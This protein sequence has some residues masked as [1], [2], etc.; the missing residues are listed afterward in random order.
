M[1]TCLIVPTIRPDSFNRFAQEWGPIADWDTTFVVFDG[2]KVP[3]G[4]DFGTLPDMRVMD[5]VKVR[6]QFG[7]AGAYAFN[8]VNSSCRGA[9]FVR[10]WH[11]G[12]DVMAT[13]DDD[14]YPDRTGT[15]AGLMAQ[16]IK[17]MD[18]TPKWCESIPQ[19]R[20]RGFPYYCD[21]PL[22]TVAAN[23]ALW[24]GVADFDG[25]TQMAFGVRHDF[26]PPRYTRVMPRG[27]FWPFCSM[28]FAIKRPYVPFIFAPPNSAAPDSRFDRMDDIWFG[29]ILEAVL[30]K[31]GKDI[32]CGPPIIRHERASNVLNNM[33]Q[34]A[35]G[36]F[37][38]EQFY[39]VVQ[40]ALDSVDFSGVDPVSSPL[41]A[42]SVMRQLALGFRRA[43][44]S[45]LIKE[46]ARKVW[47]AECS[48]KMTLWCQNFDLKY[49]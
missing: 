16:H 26:E 23:H 32:T 5:R 7:S 39:K 27:Q 43:S 22:D 42:V 14:C 21:T 34:E 13:L 4:L 20:T 29:V 31:L 40:F 8:Q 24:C 18:N 36:V 35:P 19:T 28:N 9:A 47:Y 46:P 1:K 45:D 15:D 10:A 33:K 30:D 38:N 3:D 44:E 6:Q 12:F 17:A 37:E 2:E 49:D 11:E 41:S 48:K 25:I